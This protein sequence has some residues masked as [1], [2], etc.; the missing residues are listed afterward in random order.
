MMNLMKGDPYREYYCL[1]LI[2]ADADAAVVVV[3]DTWSVSAVLLL[4]PHK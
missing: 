2:P 4:V 3:V 1:L